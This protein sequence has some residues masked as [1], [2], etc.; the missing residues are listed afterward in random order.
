[1]SRS[2][3]VD[4]LSG[5]SGLSGRQAAQS[6]TTLVDLHGPD[7]WRVITSRSRDAHDA[8]DA[9]QD[10]WISLPR[11]ARRYRPGGS[12]QER[13]ARA[14][15]MRVAY[16]SAID[17][18]RRRKSIQASAIAPP[19]PR[20]ADMDA[21]DHP[22][23]PDQRRSGSGPLTHDLTDD[24]RSSQADTDD[25]AEHSQL[26]ARV[27]AA[28][29]TLPEPY[30][31][32]LLLHLVG[33][34]SYDDLAVDLRCTVNHAR[35][36]VHR[37]VKRLREMLGVDG[38]RLHERTLASMVVPLLAMP[39]APPLPPLLPIAFAP[40]T[41]S[42]AAL[43]KV[44]IGMLVTGTVVAATVVMSALIDRPPQPVA[45]A[46]QPAVVQA[47]TTLEL[48]RF[49]RRQLGL[50]GFGHRNGPPVLALVPA[51][52]GG[53]HDT[54]LRVTWSKEHG[55][56]VDASYQPRR[57][58]LPQLTS[59]LAATATLAVWSD[60]GSGIHHVGVRFID[61]RGEIFQWQR[62]IPQPGASGW[63]TITIP[64]DEGMPLHWGN[65]PDADGV[66][67]F[68]LA[69]W[70]FGIGLD[71]TTPERAGCMLIDEVTLTIRL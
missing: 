37:G 14:W 46:P 65:T 71:A 25:L 50:L 29:G 33:G 45:P 4:A 22:D 41:G 24:P 10:F 3:T 15:L 35:V 1:M 59:D 64:L 62:P 49:D 16:T 20:I 58:P 34:L 43:T 63:R 17:H 56:W 2:P 66:I 28:I 68:P 40:P 27:Q 44:G 42:G 70:G 23:H 26:M 5:L 57:A 52:A 55:R 13:S 7:I 18:G 67:D 11:A 9:Y 38:K 47:S 69:F 36:K 60:A 31:R 32:P 54:A 8:E 6:W 30:R 39:L 48:D 53:G 19:H 51:P 12:D 21:R 61:A